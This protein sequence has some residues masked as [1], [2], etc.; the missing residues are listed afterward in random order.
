[1]DCIFLSAGIGSRLNT[2]TPKQFLKIKNKPIIL[3]SLELIHGLE[4]IDNIFLT[5]NIAFKS[6]YDKLIQE[7][8]LYKVILVEGGKTRQSSVFNALKHIKSKKVLLHESARPFISIDIINKLLEHKNEYAVVPAIQVPF[9][10]LSGNDYVE[11][12]LSRDK[13]KNIQL[14]QLFDT[15][16]LINA[17]KK[18]E[19]DNFAATE[20]S[21]LVYMYENKAVKLVEGLEYNIKITTAL[22]LKIAEYILEY[23]YS[24]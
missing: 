10:V 22:D 1:M 14:P 18:A 11:E 4:F 5:Y 23:I 6:I 19:K 2:N 21:M 9:T 7:N 15:K 3:Y 24:S 13:L 17:H 12:V 20:D 16:T 8:N